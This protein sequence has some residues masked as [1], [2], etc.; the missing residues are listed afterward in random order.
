M[1]A[2]AMAA[3]GSIDILVNNAWG[4]GKIGRVEHKTDEC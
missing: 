4:G 3:W 2:A 1:V